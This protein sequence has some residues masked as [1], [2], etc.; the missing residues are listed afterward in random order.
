MLVIIKLV[1]AIAKSVTNGAKATLAAQS[2]ASSGSSYA[3]SRQ[4]R[5]QK[6]IASQLLHGCLAI[7]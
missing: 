1:L 3:A 7:L 4:R 6:K 5:A 2:A